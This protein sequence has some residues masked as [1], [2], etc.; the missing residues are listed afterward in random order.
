MHRSPNRDAL[1]FAARQ[2]LDGRVDRNA[3]AAEA[4]RVEQDVSRNPL[5]LFYIDEA[6][7]VG[8]LPANEEVPPKRLLFTERLVLINGLDRQ[9]VCNAHRVPG[10]IE[11]PGADEDAPGRRLVDASQ[12]LDQCG[13][14]GAIIADQA[15]NLIASDGQVDVPQGMDSAEN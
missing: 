13:L 4:N 5:L 7:T 2:Q 11:L 9:L 3:D 10:E 1:P 14:S 6:Q 15:D 8:D 12:G